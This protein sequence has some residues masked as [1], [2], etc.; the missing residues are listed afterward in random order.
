MA[1]KEW[2]RQYIAGALLVVKNIACEGGMMDVQPAIGR[3][4]ND[5]KRMNVGL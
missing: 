2:K 5:E 1:S 4:I 3:S